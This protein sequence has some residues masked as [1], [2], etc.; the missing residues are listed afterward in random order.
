[1]TPTTTNS[2]APVCQLCGA[3]G[4]I[5]SKWIAPYSIYFCGDCELLFAHPIPSE[6]DLQEFYQGFLYRKPEI[7][8]IKR[9]SKSKETELKKYF[10]EHLSTGARFLDYG[11]G[12]GVASSAAMN[13]GCEVHY[14]EIDHD[15]HDFVKQNISIDSSKMYFD[16][17]QIPKE[18]FEL[19]FCDNVIE[20]VRYPNEFLEELLGYLTPGGKLVVKTPNARNYELLFFP[21]ISVLGYALRSTKY[22]SKSHF[23]K[24][25]LGRIWNCD[26][27]RHLFSFSKKSIQRLCANQN[28]VQV[29]IRY[30]H[31]PV[32][33]Y[34]LMQRYRKHPFPNSFNWFLMLIPAVLELLFKPLYVAM[35]FL[36][37]LRG[38][39]IAGVITKDRP[40][41]SGQTTGTN[42]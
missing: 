17:E 3:P 6:S 1:M 23:F 2:E 19:I 13:L 31:T 8:K 16:K 34:S 26:P 29:D 41:A 5:K 9:L 20:H 25:L 37:L 38:S 7:E 30:Y 10:G 11:A 21:K 14:Y 35:R 36:G 33:E 32:F 27:P 4:V 18:N 12:T 28:K 39:G 15:A 24:T 22:N 42:S 40:E